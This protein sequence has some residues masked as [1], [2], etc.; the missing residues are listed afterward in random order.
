MN[1]SQLSDAELDKHSAERMGTFCWKRGTEC[2]GCDAE[3]VHEGQ[4]DDIADRRHDSISG[5]WNPSANISQA[6]EFA[7]KA[8]L[9]D[10]GYVLWKSGAEWFVS[11]PLKTYGPSGWKHFAKSPT[12][13]RAITEASLKA[14]NQ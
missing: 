7:E 3:F 13:A 4:S 12:A 11:K 9:F 1:Y 8:G 14:S 5:T 2:Q 10:G 6:M